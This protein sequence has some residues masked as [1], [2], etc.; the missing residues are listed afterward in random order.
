MT[1]CVALKIQKPFKH[2]VGND[3]KSQSNVNIHLN[4]K[5]TFSGGTR[6]PPD[7]AAATS[8]AARVPP[9]VAAAISGATRAPPDVAAAISGNSTLIHLHVSKSDA[10]ASK[11]Q[12]LLC[13]R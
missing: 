7:V 10:R 3:E 6:V 11:G 8:G 9:D 1:L 12:P 2:V 4:V 13:D 5:Q